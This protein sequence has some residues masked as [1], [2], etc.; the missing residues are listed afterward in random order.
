MKLKK[1]FFIIFCFIFLS[2]IF[3]L[4]IPSIL[5][6]KIGIKFLKNQIE[7][8]TNSII[9]IES[10]KLS[11]L[12]SQSIKNLSYKD[13][14]IDLKVDA[15]TTNS[16]LISFYKSLNYYKNLGFAGNTEIANLYVDFHIPNF[17]KSNFYNVYASIKS[18]DKKLKSVNISAKT[19]ENTTEG[20]LL[21]SIEINNTRTITKIE[22]KNIPTLGIDQLLFYKKKPYQKLLIQSIGPSFNIS[23]N[24]DLNN[25]SGPINIDFVSEFSRGKINFFIE[26]NILSLKDTATFSLNLPP[27]N[28]PFIKNLNYL[29][30]EMGHP[31]VLKIF[32]DGFSLP[33]KPFEIK[34]FK[35]KHA[36]LDLN[37]LI[38]SNTGIIQT[39]SNISKMAPNDLVSIWFTD[40]NLQLQDGIIYTDRMDFLVDDTIHMCT[41]GNIN[42]LEKSL[43]LYLGITQEILQNIFGIK[44][45]PEEYIIKIPIKGSIENP[46]I[47]VSSATAK[48]LALS[49][50]QSS[51]KIGALIGNVVTQF[52][53]DKN[54]PKPKKPYPWE[55][56]TNKKQSS[57]SNILDIFKKK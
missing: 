7:K 54:I 8:Q 24:S 46:K 52:Q 47:D 42:L 10:L 55:R 27:I 17:P 9:E 4:A 21:A 11:W 41:W 18:A 57:K 51:S 34:N 39:I 32:S 35:I 25:L 19:K 20:S 36:F 26:N 48:I 44:N 33:I 12:G 5:S 23:I 45:L 43:H 50:L 29:R 1:I 49:T 56:K 2:I 3:I 53:N 30:S 38:V 31:I 14:N 15:I 16:G 13:S 6:S 40:I 28:P 22:G 37:K